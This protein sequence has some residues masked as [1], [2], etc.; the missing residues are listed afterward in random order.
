MMVLPLS[1]TNGICFV[2]EHGED[3]TPKLE[4]INAI[5]IARNT[6][7]SQEIYGLKYLFLMDTRQLCQ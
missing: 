7:D 4:T 1:V 5:V 2:V 3:G 6:V